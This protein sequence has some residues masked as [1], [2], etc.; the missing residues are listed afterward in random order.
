MIS[1]VVLIL[2]KYFEV[3]F[4]IS[5]PRVF[6]MEIVFWILSNIFVNNPYPINQGMTNQNFIVPAGIRNKMCRFVTP[7]NPRHGFFYAIIIPLRLPSLVY[8]S[9]T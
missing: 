7:R 8:F 5:F 4:L 1:L 3:I 9:P 2:F 6:F